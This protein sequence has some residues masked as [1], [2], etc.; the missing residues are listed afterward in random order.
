MMYVDHV[1]RDPIRSTHMGNQEGI[2]KVKEPMG[3]AV[4]NMLIM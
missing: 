3:I 2:I 1:S 4:M